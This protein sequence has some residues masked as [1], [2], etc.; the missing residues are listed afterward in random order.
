MAER[1][2]EFRTRTSVVSTAAPEAVFDV[3]ADLRAHLEWSGERA[4]DDTF[5]LLSLEASEY[6]A[7]VGTT[8]T[9]AGSNF[10][11]TFHDRS[12]VTEVARPSRFVVHTDARLD[13]KRGRP[14]HV[15]FEHRYD[16]QPHGTG[17]QIT[18]T[19]TIQRVNYV[20]YWL[21]FWIRPVSRRLIDRADR[22]QLE[23]LARLAEERSGARGRERGGTD[24][25]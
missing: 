25:G 4:A 19:E 7:S 18:Y 10:N 20:P 3:I 24:E 11:G 9:S 14:W 2:F 22:K 17:S 8:F 15:R 1:S 21:K 13:R 12:V 6:S 23:N 16:I 5:K